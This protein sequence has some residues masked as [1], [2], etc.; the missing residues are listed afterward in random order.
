MVSS[1]EIQMLSVQS[2]RNTGAILGLLAVG[3]QLG[4]Y[5]SF[6]KLTFDDRLG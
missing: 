1:F 6:L 2:T 4:L 3:S 5:E